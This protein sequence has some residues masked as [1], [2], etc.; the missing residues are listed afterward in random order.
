[1]SFS[2]ADT[3]PSC[4]STLSAADTP[5]FVPRFP[6]QQHPPRPGRNHNRGQ[7]TPSASHARLSLVVVFRRRSWFFRLR[8]SSSWSDCE[9]PSVLIPPPSPI[10]ATSP[11]LAPILAP[12]PIPP[13]A[14]NSNTPWA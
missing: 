13:S 3:Q 9:C 5:P 6:N 11:I 1:M 14:A 4:S 2:A 12:S 10:I 8:A 7:V